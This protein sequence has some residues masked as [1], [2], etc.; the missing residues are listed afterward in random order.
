MNILNYRKCIINIVA[1]ILVL[2]LN[3]S[4]I[5]LCVYAD[6]SGRS[7]EISDIDAPVVGELPDYDGAIVGDYYEFLV[8]D[9]GYAVN[10]ITWYNLTDDT[11]IDEYTTFEDGKVYKVTILIVPC[12]GNAWMLE[13]AFINGNYADVAEADDCYLI[14]YTFGEY[15]YVDTDGIV[16]I[17]DVESP[18]EGAYPDYS[19]TVES[20]FFEVFRD[21]YGY[22]YDG[23]TWFDT[24]LQS[25]LDVTDA[26][27]G[28]HIYS[29]T[30]LLKKQEG[31]EIPLS[32]V[33]INGKQASFYETDGY[34]V[35]S[36]SFVECADTVIRSVALELLREPV[37]GAVPCYDVYPDNDKYT[38][39]ESKNDV[40]YQYGVC[41]YD[42][43]TGTN[44]EIG[45]DKFIE[46]HEYQLELYLTPKEHYSFNLK[47]ATVN[48]LDAEIWGGNQRVVLM[49]SFGLC[50]KAETVI[51]GDI[52]STYN[53]EDNAVIVELYELTR[54]ELFWSEAI[55]DEY[56]S[57]YYIE[58][59]PSGEYV[60]VVNKAEHVERKYYLY[61]EDKRIITQ[62]VCIAKMGDCDMDGE[63]DVIDYQQ[64]VNIAVSCDR[65]VPYYT[66]EDWEYVLA[67]SDY[68]EDGCI[69]ALDCAQV[70]LLANE[71]RSY[72]C[73]EITDITEPVGGDLPTYSA[74]VIGEGYELY[75][76]EL[77][78]TYN[79]IA[80]Y[81][82]TED[83]NLDK[84][85]VFIEGHRY[86]VTIEVV[87]SQGGSWDLKYAKYKDIMVKVSEA[88]DCYLITF[89]FQA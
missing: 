35:A 5:S 7:V 17:T 41:W 8:E 60:L 75:D 74:T 13:E 38:L 43:T 12:N 89:E 72:D 76:E 45:V 55:D 87:P 84:T 49:C 19:V 16:Y 53:P 6:D 18:V 23:V 67:V 39:N 52:W 54:E 14:S 59:V 36:Y 71:S 9:Y 42:V 30:I 86:S 48:S 24:T 85:D 51:R 4:G 78:Y 65:W 20:E 61:V 37:A 40:Y 73:I 46:G 88:S 47:S 31:C 79:G 57:D 15:E 34:Y 29:V 28:D 1:V 77:G 69:D 81:D 10:G 44:L 62:D 26:F 25:N 22:I 32:E 83:S 70:A 63:I 11:N 68:A 3:L 50:K 66:T 56:Y 58:G 80:W 33:Y 27:L 82:L 64:I 21:N 2:A